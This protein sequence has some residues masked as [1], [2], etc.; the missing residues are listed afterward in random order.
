VRL[1]C[2]AW[3]ATGDWVACG[4]EN[5]LLKVFRYSDRDEAEEAEEG[6]DDANDGAEA[7]RRPP[8]RPPSPPHLQHQTLEGHAS[9]VVLADFCEPLGKLAT[10]DHSGL[11]VVWSLRSQ[12]GGGGRGQDASSA[13]ADTMLWEEEAVHRATAS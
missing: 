2:V 6:D 10:A 4:G 12:G 11:V 3:H 8:R 13:N 5:G 7:A 9:A 1:R